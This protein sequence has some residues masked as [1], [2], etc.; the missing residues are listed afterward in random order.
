PSRPDFVLSC[1]HCHQPIPFDSQARH[2]FNCHGCGSSFRVENYHPV[3]TPGE[4]RLLGRFQL[5]ECVGQGTFGAV[6]R[7]HD[8]QL[9]RIVA[10]NIPHTSLLTTTSYLERF[11]REARAA[12]QLSH[13]GI[14]RLYDVPMLDDIPVLVSDFIDG[15]PL[16]ELIETKRLTFPESAALL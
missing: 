15:V 6:W 10:L 9:D 1:P 13:P 4:V 3:S 2:Q 11:R 5:L 14:V 16:R 8:T 12:A 7:A